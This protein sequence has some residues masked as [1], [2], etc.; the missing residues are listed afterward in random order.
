MHDR[1][2]PTE[3]LHRIRLGRLV[4]DVALGGLPAPAAGSDDGYLL[5]VP[6]EG[7][8]GF[9]RG[10][11]AR[12]VEA[13]EYVLFGRLD[14]QSVEAAGARLLVLRIP[15]EDLRGRVVS[16]D[17]H[18]ERR[19]PANE[20]MTRLLVGLLGSIA[21]LF[22]DHPPPTPEALATELLSFVALAIG[23]EDRG[24][25]LAVRNAR[26][27]LRRRIFDYIDRNLADPELNPRR[28]ADEARISLS[29]LYSLFS[30]D[31]TTVGQFMQSRRL[32]RAYEI[33]VADPKKHLTVSEIAYQVGFKN[34]SHFSRSFSRHFGM[35]PREARP[36]P[37]RPA[38]PVRSGARAYSEAPLA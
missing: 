29:Y 31:D 27:R 17:D 6:V 10:G 19:F 33:L 28:I 30:D 1:V 15:A 24:A 9:G 11:R 16:V 14:G 5:V 22:A 4:L 36:E 38:A 20:R 21:E 23:A 25:T 8:L 12:T 7:R 32:Q 13:G 34:V 18:V 3:P 2:P 37:T 35:A 26:Y